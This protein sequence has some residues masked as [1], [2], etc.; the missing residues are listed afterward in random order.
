M[1]LIVRSSSLPMGRGVA[2]SSRGYMS[3]VRKWFSE[4]SARGLFFFSSRRRHTR[5]DCDW[6]S[7]VCSSDLLHVGLDHA[8]G[9]PEADPVGGGEGASTRPQGRRAGLRGGAGGGARAAVDRGGQIGRASCR[10]RVEISVVAVSLK[11]KKKHMNWR[12]A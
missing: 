10:E 7:D 1:T 11:K 2:E 8:R 9:A 12:Q 3:K 4:R 6:S 5:F